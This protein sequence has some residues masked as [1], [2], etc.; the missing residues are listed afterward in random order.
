MC[1]VGDVRLVLPIHA[2]REYTSTFKIPFSIEFSPL[3]F[4]VSPIFSIIRILLSVKS[5]IFGLA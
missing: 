2:E 5:F 4:C 3:T 1:S